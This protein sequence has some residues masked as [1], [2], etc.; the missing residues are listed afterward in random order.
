MSRITSVLD[1]SY[2]GLPY[3]T[4]WQA[5]KIIVPSSL[6]PRRREA[7]PSTTSSA[8][9]GLCG[10]NGWN[11]QLL[12]H[13]PRLF[14]P[15]PHI[16]STGHLWQNQTA[17]SSPSSSVILLFFFSLIQGGEQRVE[18]QVEGFRRTAGGR[19]W[20]TLNGDEGEITVSAIKNDILLTCFPRHIQVIK[21]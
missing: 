13:S 4:A 6:A 20:K 18:T 9:S 15:P 1:S 12:R 17:L 10:P 14:T 11:D 3:W 16:S 2:I 5:P 7:S 8:L 21:Y 19:K